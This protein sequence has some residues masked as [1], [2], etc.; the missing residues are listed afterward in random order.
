MQ[1]TDFHGGHGAIV[2]MV[3]TTSLQLRLPFLQV[4]NK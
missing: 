1:A 3:P 4:E 2:D